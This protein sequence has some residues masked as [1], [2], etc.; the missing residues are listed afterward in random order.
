MVYEEVFL[1][2]C[3]DKLYIDFMV[4]R[5][6]LMVE[7]QGRQHREFVEHFHGTKHGFLNQLKRDGW[8]REWAALNQF[9]LVCLDD[10]Q[11]AW[12]AAELAGG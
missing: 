1:P 7:V 6:R 2:G 10:T 5:A 9:R 3:E 4:P 8:K 11:Q 12:W